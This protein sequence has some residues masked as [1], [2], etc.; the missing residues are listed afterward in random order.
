[1]PDLN[2]FVEWVKKDPG[3]RTVDIKI[4]GY[5]NAKNIK[6]WVYDFMLACGQYVA[7]VDEICLEQKKEAE[8]RA[9]YES[10][11]QKYEQAAM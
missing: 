3:V 11:K 4:G 6:I 9:N 5:C 8:E 10:L 7:S 2:K 1:M